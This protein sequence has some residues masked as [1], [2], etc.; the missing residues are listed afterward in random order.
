MAPAGTPDLEALPHVFPVLVASKV[1]GIG[2]NQTYELIKRGTY[3]VRV[4]TINGR[5]K[6]SR[7]D[8]L[9]YLGAPGYSSP[10]PRPAEPSEP[11][12]RAVGG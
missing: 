8:L 10:A 6:V 4:L 9:A 7:Y 1:L 11:S 3:P 5:F 12:L 2:K